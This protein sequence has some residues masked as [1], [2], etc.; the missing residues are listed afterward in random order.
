MQVELHVYQSWIE[1]ARNVLADYD[2]IR[3]VEE[4]PAL[5]DVQLA[6]DLA[7]ILEDLLHQ[8]LAYDVVTLNY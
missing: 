8:I 1:R 7:N 2:E 4:P 6:D 3:E 5:V